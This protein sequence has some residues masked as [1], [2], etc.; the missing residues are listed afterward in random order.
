MSWYERTSPRPPGDGPLP[1]RSPQP[2]RSPACNRC[3]RVPPP[4]PPATYRTPPPSDAWET[5][6]AEG[7]HVGRSEALHEWEAAMGSARAAVR[8]ADALWSS[9]IALG[10]ILLL[11][12]ALWGLAW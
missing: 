6:Y 11:T 4:E 5:G 7:L 3:G 12:L 2:S 9:A 10:C 8:L 1:S